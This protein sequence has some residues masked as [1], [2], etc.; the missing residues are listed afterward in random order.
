MRN[1]E[2]FISFCNEFNKFNNIEALMLASNYHMI[3]I[4]FKNRISGVKK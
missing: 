3:L 4:L 2:Y 1:A